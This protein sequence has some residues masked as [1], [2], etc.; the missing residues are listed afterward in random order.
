NLYVFQFFLIPSPSMRETL[1]EGDRVCVS[2]FTYGIEIFP[3][4][5]KIFENRT[6]DRDD[7]I[8]FYNPLYESKGPVFDVVS[9]ML[10]MGTFSLVNIDVDEDGNMR[11][12]LLVKR[13]AAVGGDTVTFINGNA[14]I[15]ASGTDE[16]VNE[17]IFRQ[18]NNLSEAPHRTIEEETYVGYN[19]QGRLQG[20]IN[21]GITSTYLPRHLVTD[22]SNL[23]SNAFF[24]DYYG[25]YMAIATG[26]RM[27]D[28]TDVEAVSTWAKYK[29]GVYVPEG[30]VLPLGDNRDNSQ[31][32]RYFGPVPSSSING[33]VVYRFWPFNRIASLV[34]K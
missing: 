3:Q 13:A 7:I 6:P 2:K 32:G 9:T 12:K 31:D 20:L 11:E 30:Y 16:F 27:G 1:L 33:H 28:P 8:T 19:A 34:D 5:Q 4:G 29:N 14:Y 17:A 15:K 22:Q 18:E 24:T 21:T 23:D 26:E 25:Y 10:F